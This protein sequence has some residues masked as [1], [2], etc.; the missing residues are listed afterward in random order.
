QTIEHENKMIEER[1]EALL[2][3]LSGL[4]RALIRSLGNISLPHMQEPITEQNFDSYVS[5]LTHMYTN[6]D[7]FQSAENK[8][9]LETI[10]RAVKGIKV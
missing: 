7:R 1:N 4:S 5:T 2:P 6:K 9:L 8:A 3:K 10:N